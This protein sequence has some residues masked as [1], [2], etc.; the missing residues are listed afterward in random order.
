MWAVGWK[1]NR[2]RDMFILLLDANK[3]VNSIITSKARYPSPRI[4]SGRAGAPFQIPHYLGGDF[5]GCFCP[6]GFRVSGKRVCISE[7][8]QIKVVRMLKEHRSHSK[9]Q[10]G[11]LK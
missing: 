9:T 7:H 4:S 11:T 1:N 3:A 6:W 8:S 10:A 2:P 5:V